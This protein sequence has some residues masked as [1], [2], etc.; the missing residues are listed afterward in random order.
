MIHRLDPLE[1]AKEI[2]GSYKRYLKTL[3]APRD[4]KLAGAF[5]AEVDDSDLLTKGPILEMTPPYATGATCRELIAEGVLH[6]GFAALDGPALPMD[7]P[8][9]IHQ[10]AAIRKFV[11]G[12][13]LVVSTGTGSGKT[14]SFLCATRR[15][16]VSPAQAGG[17]R[18]EVLGSDGLPRS[19]R[20]TGT[21]AC[22]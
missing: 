11:A 17:T 9:Y 10:E 7:Q 12:R 18:K 13:N 15:A 19:E 21:G 14:E 5:D 4:E 20:L 1:A 22:Q 8:L 6:P 16:V 3:L 2:E